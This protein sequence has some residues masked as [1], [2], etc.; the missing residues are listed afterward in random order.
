VIWALRSSLRV[1]LAL[2][3]SP[4]LVTHASACTVQTALIPHL[5][6][7]SVGPARSA[8]ALYR[9]YDPPSD[10]CVSAPTGSGKT[11]AYAVPIVEVLSSRVVSR[12]RALVVL[13]TRDL[14]TQ[15]SLAGIDQ[16][17]RLIKLLG[18]YG[19]RSSPWQKA[20]VCGLEA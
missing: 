8:R 12:L 13:P 7:A 17:W 4:Q 15:V 9:P 5:L 10:V 3:H 18:R 11:L 6:P 2:L 16:G 20:L 14:V 1:R 19:I